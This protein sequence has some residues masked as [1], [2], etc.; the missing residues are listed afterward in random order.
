MELLFHQQLREMVDANSSVFNTHDKF[1]ISCYTTYQRS[2][3]S[4]LVGLKNIEV[5][6]KVHR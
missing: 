5:M 3:L 2:H 4:L 1:K 6:S